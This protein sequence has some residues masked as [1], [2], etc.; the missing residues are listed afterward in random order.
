MEERINRR[1]MLTQR[2]AGENGTLGSKQVG[3]RVITGNKENER[4]GGEGK[5]E[6]E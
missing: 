5:V 6:E 4:K 2:Y 1:R 3:P